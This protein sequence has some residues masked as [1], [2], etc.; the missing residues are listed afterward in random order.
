MNMCTLINACGSAVNLSLNSQWGWPCAI[1]ARNHMFLTIL[2]AL[3]LFQ[4]HMRFALI[5]N[6]IRSAF[7]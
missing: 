2:N 7:R 1:A 6:G 4:P 3:E 5:D